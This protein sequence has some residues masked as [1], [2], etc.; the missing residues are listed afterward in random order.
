MSIPAPAPTAEPGYATTE[1]YVT[2]VSMVV[3]FL[4]QLGVIHVGANVDQISALVE[5]VGPVVGYAISRGIRKRGTP[6]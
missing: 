3:G 1:F 5:M 4:T 2:I 6:S